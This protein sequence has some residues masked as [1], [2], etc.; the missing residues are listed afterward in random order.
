MA[1]HID[2]ETVTKEI[3]KLKKRKQRD[4]KLSL[5][6]KGNS[7]DEF[8][9]RL[10]QFC[11][12]FG[13]GMLGENKYNE[14]RAG[15]DKYPASRT[16]RKMFGSWKEAC[17]YTFGKSNCDFPKPEKSQHL[18]NSSLCPDLDESSIVRLMIEYKVSSYRGLLRCRMKFPELFPT[19]HCIIEKFGSFGNLMEIVKKAS[20]NSEMEKLVELRMKK[21]GRL[22][23]YKELEK[24][25]I[26]VKMLRKAFGSF[27][28]VRML[29]SELEFAIEIQ[30]RN[31][32]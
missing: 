17:R 11:D 15:K 2:K 31:Q 10:R 6:V 14:L 24:A 12:M 32:R 20:V 5:T 13:G 22:S 19:L 9:N 7:K 3:S 29:S 23:S 26:N 18:V 28:K 27:Q 21:K 8:A 30:K 16:Y 4:N 25:G 1:Y